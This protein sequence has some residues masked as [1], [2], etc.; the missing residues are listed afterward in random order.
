MITDESTSK[1]E[2]VNIKNKKEITFEKIGSDQLLENASLQVKLNDQ[3]LEQWVSSK[4]KKTISLE[5]GKI[6]T[7]HEESAPD[8]YLVAQDIQ[9]KIDEQGQVFYK[10]K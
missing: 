6:Y 8:G 3:V 4:E 10:N 5:V 9:F 7:Y 1:I 2:Y